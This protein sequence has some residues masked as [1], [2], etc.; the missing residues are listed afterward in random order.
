MKANIGTADAPVDVA[1]FLDGDLTIKSEGTTQYSLYLKTTKPVVTYGAKDYASNFYFNA[2]SK[3]VTITNVDLHTDAADAQNLNSIINAQYSQSADSKMVFVSSTIEMKMSGKG[4]SSFLAPTTAAKEYISMQLDG[5]DL[6]MIGTNSTQGVKL[7]ANQSDEKLLSSITMTD[8]ASGFILYDGTVVKNL[9]YT[10]NGSQYGGLTIK[11][12]VKVEDS[13]IAVSDVNKANYAGQA[14]ITFDAKEKDVELDAVGTSIAAPSMKIIG[15]N[16]VAVNGG[17]VSIDKMLKATTGTSTISMNGTTISNDLEMIAG[18]TL[19]VESGASLT[20]GTGATLSGNTADSLVATLANA[21]TVFNNGTIENITYSGN[22]VFVAGAGSTTTAAGLDEKS[23]NV[24]GTGK[25]NGKAPTHTEGT[26]GSFADLKKMLEAG[27]PTINTQGN[28]TISEDIVIGSGITVITKTNTYLDIGTHAIFVKGGTIDGLIKSGDSSNA[29]LVKFESVTG[30]FKVFKWNSIDIDAT[31]IQGTVTVT[32]GAAEITGKITGDLTIATTTSNDVVKFS[33]VTVNSGVKLTLSGPGKFNVEAEKTFNLY[34]SLVNGDNTSKNVQ[35]PKKA[36]FKAFSGSQIAGTISVTGP[37][38]STGKIGEAGTIDLSQAQNPQTVGEDISYDKTY[39]QLE[40]VTVVGSLTIK[41]NSTVKVY[42]GFQ[43]NEGVTLTI[44]KGSKLLID[45]SAASM[46][47]DGRII[48]EEGATLEVKNANDV[49]VSGS[50]ESEGVVEISSNVTVKSGGSIIIKDATVTGGVYA[51]T[52]E[53]SK[54][55]TI[56]AGAE[57]TIKSKINSATTVSN[58]GTVTLD[59]AVLGGKFTINMLADSAVVDIQSVTGTSEVEITDNGLKFADKKTEV[60]TTEGYTDKVNS[61]KFTLGEGVTLKGLTVVEKVSSYVYEGTTYYTNTMDI[62]GSV[63]VASETVDS[64]A[65]TVGVSGKNLAVTGTL[66]LGKMVTLNVTGTESV[67]KVTGTVTATEDGSVI[68]S[69]GTIDVTGLVQTVTKIDSGI[70][71]AMYETKS[72]TDTIYNY[73]TLKAAVDSGAKDIAV[74]GEISVSESLTVPA[75]VTVKNNGIIVV[76]SADSTDVVLTFADGA[77]VKY[78][79]IDVKGTL[80]FDN[81]KNNKA[82]QILSDVSVIGDVSSKYTNLYTALSEAQA[83]DTVT[84]TRDGTVSI[85]KNL[86][87]K[88]GVTLDV[89]NSKKISVADG[90]TL[91]VAGTLKTAEAVDAET[92]FAEKASARDPKA[93]AIVVTGTFMSM[94]PVE[95]SNYVI[96]G[97]YYSL[98]DSVG[99]YNYVTTVENAAKVAASVAGGEIE[100]NGKVSAGDIAFTGTSTQTVRITVM[101]GA[102]FTVASVTLDDARLYTSGD[103]SAV[104]VFTGR[105]V[106][107]DSAVDAKNAYIWAGADD[108]GQMC[109]FVQKTFEGEPVSYADRNSDSTFSVSSGKV[110]VEYAGIKVTVAS[111]ATLVSYDGYESIIYGDLQIDGTVSVGS[112]ETISVTGN[113]IVNGV[114]SVADE[115]DTE[116]AGTFEVDGVM[117]VGVTEKATT[118]EDV[119][120]SGP[121][122]VSK[123]VVAS[124]GASISDSTI[125]SFKNASGKLVSTTYVVEDKDWIVVYSI[126]GTAKIGVIKK[127]PVEN[128]KFEGEWKNSKDK[129]ANNELVGAENFDKVYAV[130]EYDIYTIQITSCAGIESIAIDGNLLDYTALYDG[131]KV[132]AGSHTISYSLMNGYSGDA[133]LSLVSSDDKT[134]ASVSGM[135]FTVSGDKGVVKLQLTGIEKSGYVD[136]SPDMPAEDKDDGLTV[137]DYLL[138]VLV[139]LIVIMA[140]IVAMRLMRS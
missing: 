27:M 49:T 120:V 122:D 11:G 56:E 40:N 1:F 98:T 68:T 97:A 5:S 37:V 48:V 138:I 91:T 14:A 130:I 126:D 53:A 38:D 15:T 22:G 3:T 71:A 64:P 117:Y 43:V 88:E 61:I 52:F 42:G 125:D 24:I 113:V 30:D 74:L 50:I 128:A 6:T 99:A 109:V 110:F 124:V 76:G 63:A 83:G 23:E 26:V 21:G 85:E 17:N 77:S 115:T 47:V 73:S 75:G 116:N 95:Y 93:S 100:I 20:V 2:G 60:G 94:A 137:T 45:S 103:T 18:T 108:D 81:K 80:V 82:S 59:G 140:V 132:K 32:A 36:T 119:S 58:K 105:I 84:I 57:L 135:S 123:Y 44:E 12:K 69:A 41:N 102:M 92:A 8:V 10:L 46:I 13:K 127:A 111:G 129:D 7:T 121:V 28:P 90:V 66:A 118:G 65:A 29:E 107:G 34:G 31:K 79:T 72:G 16:A 139:V 112:G 134:T 136:P 9:D 51:S 4:A 89:P 67:L 62:A 104:G 70:N 114:L 86:T 96:A 54:G 19:N 25:V 33:D 133:K 106:I 87:I 78:G 55:L 39:G 35:V 101:P 131:L